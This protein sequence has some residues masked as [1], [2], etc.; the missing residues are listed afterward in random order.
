MVMNQN[1]SQTIRTIVLSIILGFGSGV[2]GTAVTTNALSDY[3]LSL[4]ALS[5]PA[6]LSEEQPRS[7]PQSYTDVIREITESV[8][9]SV[10]EFYLVGS[11]E[12]S[13][14]SGAVLTS[15][16][17]IMT[18]FEALPS[19]SNLSVVI[20][21]KTYRVEQLVSDSATGV[22]FAKIN[23]SNLPVF[24]FG[25]GFDLTAGDQ[26][27]VTPSPRT[28]FSES[29]VEIVWRKGAQPSDSPGRTILIAT[30]E[31]DEF[32]APVVNIHGDLVGI[33]DGANILPTDIV[34]TGFNSLLREG[35]ISRP[36]L[37][38]VATDLSRSLG[39]DKTITQGYSAGAALIGST[40]VKKGSS[41][42][43][44]GLVPGDIILTINGTPIDFT[45]SLDELIFSHNP[46]DTITL[47]VASA[48]GER[49]IVVTLSTL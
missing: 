7:I 44:A 41:G 37:G 49:E 23:S 21:G 39:L 45:H 33:I 48:K 32:G 22:V 13:I 35:K 2:I 16:G 29:V 20:G 43:L 46:G 6:R 24:A 26:L 36:S 14:S 3:A 19:T 38:V 17:W 10:A 9:P 1:L 27:F 42:A 25:K 15:D 34:L 12:K 5:S 31:R 4:G 30:D 28:I 47:Q 11:F 40:S 8:L 18:M